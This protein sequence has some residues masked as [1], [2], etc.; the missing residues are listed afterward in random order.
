MIAILGMQG[1]RTAIGPVGERSGLQDR[2][3]WVIS[4]EL[5]YATVPRHVSDVAQEKKT[6]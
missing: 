2:I 5:P 1:R 6:P 3:N 4:D